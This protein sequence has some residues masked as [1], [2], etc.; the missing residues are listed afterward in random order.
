ME[1][2]PV[3]K[4]VKRKE[5]SISSNSDTSMKETGKRVKAEGMPVMMKEEL[6]ARS[7]KAPEK[8]APEAPKETTH[9]RKVVPRKAAAPGQTEAKKPMVA[10]RRQL[11]E[12]P[13][14]QMTLPPLKLSPRHFEEYREPVSIPSSASSSSRKSSSVK[15]LDRRVERSRQKNA[16]LVDDAKDM[17][18]ETGKYKRKEISAADRVRYEKMKK[19]IFDKFEDLAIKEEE[20]KL[21]LKIP[22]RKPGVTKI[23]AELNAQ[24]NKD[25]LEPANAILK[26]KDVIT[27]LNTLIKEMPLTSVE[28]ILKFKATLLALNILSND[29]KALRSLPDPIIILEKYADIHDRM[30]AQYAAEITPL[31]DILQENREQRLI[32]FESLNTLKK[33][34]PAYKHAKYYVGYYDS[35]MPV[36]SNL[37][38]TIMDENRADMAKLNEFDKIKADLLPLK[39]SATDITTAYDAAMITLDEASK[40]AKVASKTASK[41][42]VLASPDINDLIDFFKKTLIKNERKE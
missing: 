29:L 22:Q 31:S 14:E 25:I 38:K 5:I 33:E 2:D 12:L 11:L 35:I 30:Q 10:T 18:Q 9:R 34:D 26:Y 41:E 37:L 17:L 42:A 23:Y 32:Y 28:N 8:Y 15:V 7:R 13:A 1:I 19:N 39:Q 27:A 3:K 4:K 6:P 36:V 24:F 16:A 20:P 40:E 21:K